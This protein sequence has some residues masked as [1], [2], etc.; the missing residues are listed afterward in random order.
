MELLQLTY[1]CDAAATQNFS[2]TAKRF[3]VPPSNISQSIKRLEEELGVPL[4]TR[5]ATLVLP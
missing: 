4:F 5:S 3:N 1:F 2:Q